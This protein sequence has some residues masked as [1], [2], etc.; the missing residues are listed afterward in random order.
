MRAF[1]AAIVLLSL[2][3]PARTYI[4]SPINVRVTHVPEWFRTANTRLCFTALSVDPYYVPP[5]ASQLAS[6]ASPIRSQLLPAA[7]WTLLNGASGLPANVA[8]VT[9]GK[10][11]VSGNYI[12]EGWLDLDGDGKYDPGEPYG[13]EQLYG[14]AETNKIVRVGIEFKEVSP[15]IARM[16]VATLVD[17][18]PPGTNEPPAFAPLAVAADRGRWSVPFA[19]VLPTSTCG[20]NKPGSASA[21]VRVRVVRD[22]INDADR[23]AETSYR[24]VLIDRFQDLSARRV[25]T[26]ADIMADNTFDLDFG[27]LNKAYNGLSTPSAALTNA[28]YRIVI[29]DGDVGDYERFGNNLPI[30]FR[31][32]FE[33]NGRQTPTFGHAFH[34]T[35]NITS[36]TTNVYPTFCWSH[37][38]YIHKPYPAFRLRIYSNASMNQNAILHDTNIVRAPPRSVLGVYSYTL[39]LRIGDSMVKYVDGAPVVTGMFTGGSNYWWAVSMLDAKFYGM[40]SAETANEFIMP[41]CTS[42]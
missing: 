30:L 15:S 34:L 17:A 29:G 7:H 4:T 42:P 22:R 37:T 1:A 25:L 26:E 21:I 39:P 8:L 33:K 10:K 6:G 13:C 19:A 31:N 11:L 3:C 18:M 38:N 36:S 5:T 20:T 40:S 32:E 2:P 9:D 28:T 23:L 27:Y 12:L 35:T 24:S 41:P 16:D 14:L